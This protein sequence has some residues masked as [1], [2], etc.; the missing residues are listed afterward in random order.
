ML[1]RYGDKTKKSTE[2]YHCRF[3]ACNDPFN[4]TWTKQLQWGNYAN[5][6]NTY[7][8]PIR[9]YIS[10][11]CSNIVNKTVYHNVTTNIDASEP[12][13]DFCIRSIQPSLLVKA[14]NPSF[15]KILEY[16]M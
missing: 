11:T 16:W 4:F 8:I 10:N 1:S 13:V 2:N 12:L 7:I 14:N 9:K 15:Q 5:E 6:A 3:Y